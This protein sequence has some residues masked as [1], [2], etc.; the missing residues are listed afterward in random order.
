MIDESFA[1]NSPERSLFKNPKALEENRDLFYEMVPEGLSLVMSLDELHKL[2]GDKPA[3]KEALEEM[4]PEVEGLILEFSELKR[5]ER[6]HAEKKEKGGPKSADES[7]NEVSAVNAQI[8]IREQVLAM[9]EWVKT[10]LANQGVPPSES[11]VKAVEADSGD[12]L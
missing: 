1:G 8:K 7:H 11:A 9:H 4:L 3:A 6:E 5:M 12:S 10:L 2:Y